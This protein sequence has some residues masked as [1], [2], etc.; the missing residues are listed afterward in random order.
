MK[1][2]AAFVMLVTASTLYAASL[3]PVGVLDPANPY[4]EIRALSA[5][6]VYA[7]GSSYGTW[8]YP[9]SSFTGNGP[10]IWSMS[11]GLVAL[12][13]PSGAA[14]IAHGVAV[15]V[16]S[17]AGNIIVSGL[18]EGNL[19]HRYY[20]APQSNL[21]GGA[22]SDTA[23]AGGWA[24]SSL[25]GGSW[26]DLRNAVPDGT[27]WPP[28]GAWYTGARRD[29]GRTAFLRGDPF[30]GWDGNN[31]AAV[32]SISSYAVLVG[33]SSKSPSTAFFESS[34]SANPFTDV[35]G[36]SGFRADGHGISSSFGKSATSDF[37]VQWICG[38][39]QNYNG[40][41][42][43]MQAFRWKRGDASMTFLGSLA[44]AGGG[45][46]GNNSSCAY[47][48]ADNGIT[49]GR[50]YFGAVG[51]NPA[52]EVATVWGVDGL[53]QSLEAILADAGVD[54]SAWTHLVRVYAISDDGKTLAGFGIWAADGSTRGFV[55][56][57]DDFI[58]K[59]ACCVTTGLGT[60]TCSHVTSDECDALGGRYLGDG[61][62]CGANNFNCGGF[63]PIPFADADVDGDVDQADFAAFQACFTGPLGSSP[64]L[65]DA[66]ACL[67]RGL[68]AS[69]GDID[70]DDLAAFEECATGP[71]I[72]WVAEQLPSCVPGDGTLP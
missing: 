64:G 66:C 34:S 32:H 23:N 71:G 27:G 6:G 54:T 46:A 53:P 52:Y 61:V 33:R 70:A 13:C 37:D 7:V 14:T 51:E 16:G 47:A 55:A 19:V 62:Q 22:W 58:V 25:R 41:G 30:V 56:H 42:T 1:N 10:I 26:N 24:L 17:N 9:T 63:C 45:D 18:H 72:P 29:V 50:S 43:T 68:G 59:G 15:G 48:I 69:D 5:D 36:S 39:A 57:L 35:P 28:L 2:I 20:K 49:A 31:V 67:D 40:P 65:A 38:Q 21:A 4:S 11:D 8:V 44:P 60:G 12:P 3:I